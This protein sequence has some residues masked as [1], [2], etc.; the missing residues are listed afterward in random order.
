MSKSSGRALTIIPVV[1]LAIAAVAAASTLAFR[2]PPPVAQPLAINHAL[3]IA[4]EKMECTECH[5]EAKTSIY[6]GL[7][8]IKECYQCHKEPLGE[9]PDEPKVREF[10]KKKQQ[11]PFVQV[12]RNVGHV[13]FSHRVH[14]TLAEMQCQDCHGDLTIIEGP[15]SLANPSLHSMGACMSCHQEKGASL[16]CVA[17]HK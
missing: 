4:K 9:H 8:D 7:P 12:N 3:H 1:L 15:V 16:E 13:Y 6:A 17:C 2:K 11:L 14:V 5:R 10:A